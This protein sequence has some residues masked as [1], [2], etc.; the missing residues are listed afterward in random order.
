MINETYRGHRVTKLLAKTEYATVYEAQNEAGRRYALKFLNTDGVPAAIVDTLFERETKALQGFEQEGIATLRNSWR[1]ADG[2]PVLVFDLVPGE[3]TLEQDIVRVEEG[4]T[5][6]SLRWRFEQAIRLI[7]AVSSAH[8]RHVVHRD[9]KPRNI[10]LDTDHDAL[11]LIDF[12]VAN[13]LHLK[14]LNPGGRTVR[15]FYTRPYAA[16]EQRAQK[17]SLAAADVHALGLVLLSLLSMRLPD[18]D[19]TSE[20]FDDLWESAQQEFDQALV[21]ADKADV[22]RERL[23]ACLAELPDER[24]SLSLLHDAFATVLE[25]VKPLPVAHI[26]LTHAVEE[27]MTSVGMSPREAFADLQEG[28]SMRLDRDGDT[29]RIKIYGKSTFAVAAWEQSADKIF[30]RLIDFGVLSGPQLSND[31]RQAHPVRLEL[32]PGRGDG[33]AL[34]ELAEE[35]RAYV[36]SERVEKLLHMAE[37]VIKHEE[38]RIA[39]VEV[40]VEIL[41]GSPVGKEEAR[42][43]VRVKNARVRIHG[44]MPVRHPLRS[45]LEDDFEWTFGLDPATVPSLYESRDAMQVVVG[46]HRQGV[47]MRW[48]GDEADIAFDKDDERPR[49]FKFLMFDKMK[50]DQLNAQRNAIDLLRTRKSALTRLPELLTLTS[51]H[52]LN[53]LQPIEPFQ[54]F[55]KKD[56]RVRSIIERV[57]ASTVSCV[58]GPPGTGKTTLIVELVLHLLRQNPR[59]RILVCSQ[60]NE[61][62]ANALERLKSEEVASLAGQRAWIVRDVR[63]ELQN[64]DDDGFENAFATESALIR[65]RVVALR[66]ALDSEQGRG[67]VDD[68]AQDL[69]HGANGTKRDFAAHV[70]VWGATTARSRSTLSR[71]AQ[72]EHWDVVIVDEAAKVTLAEVLVPLVCAK[73]IVLVGDHKQLPAFLDSN[74]AEQLEQD[75]LDPDEAKLSLFEHLF[76]SVLPDDQVG[77]MVTQ[78]RMHPSIGA[79]VSKL[80]YDGALKHNVKPDARPLPAGRFDTEHR[81]FF[82]GFRGADEQTPEKSRKNVAE[83]D[84]IGRVLESLDRDARDAGTR[85]SVSV[86]TPYKAQAKVLR[87]HEDTPRKALDVRTGTVDSFQG[88]QSDVVLYSLVR[89][90]A[91]E[92]HFLADTRR[93]NVALSRAKA[94]LILVGD[95]D[96]APATP[97]LERLLAELPDANK[98]A[99]DS[100]LD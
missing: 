15:D 49:R 55:L 81:V 21:P 11:V 89:T 73:R 7:A 76:E 2:T 68:W 29:P 20:D 38:E 95:L 5:D 54:P 3:T 23:L 8:Q 6:R 77:R 69:E 99:L 27:K 67:A 70:Q 39:K 4:R 43:R 19:Y 64:G 88:R 25:S 93:F 80:F 63:K 97:I 45:I 61:A 78:S 31:R 56:R 96:S 60:A 30:V 26:A 84:A 17:Q 36:Q 92:W 16:P 42:G 40:E 24:P 46:P 94:L 52:R 10:L 72:A 98:V 13:V 33:R 37:W 65:E 51:G 74:T 22:L 100:F 75:G 53:N 59:Q 87:S 12:G 34:V 86:I 58:Q 83:S 47:V 14:I 9:I 48:N 18:D 32:V 57:L 1:E 71:L 35:T 91:T 28:L 44:V 82:L 50:T 66:D 85:L 41:N 79:V 90:G 62:V